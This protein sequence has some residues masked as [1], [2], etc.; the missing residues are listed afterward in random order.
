MN[1]TT[2]NN[3][4]K[5]NFDTDEAKI[6]CTTRNNDLAI[7]NEESNSDGDTV[8]S[9]DASGR[10]NHCIQHIFY[11]LNLFINKL[12]CVDT[13]NNLKEEKKIRDERQSL[14]DELKKNIVIQQFLEIFKAKMKSHLKTKP[15]QEIKSFL[16]NFEN[17]LKQQKD[18][19]W[20]QTRIDLVDEN[21]DQFVV[22]VI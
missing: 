11:K 1:L 20:K 22:F 19:F 10:L 15:K 9:N 8:K 12:I 21:Y 3:N 2:L 17:L 4:L 14:F 13:D 5:L 18:K 6:N 16:S 7:I